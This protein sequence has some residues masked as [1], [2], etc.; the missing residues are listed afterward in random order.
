MRTVILFLL[1]INIC[2]P[3]Y[4]QVIKGTIFDQKTDSV[5]CFATVYFNGT[6]VGTTSDVNGNFKLNVSKNVSMPLTISAVGYYSLTLTDYSTS[7]PLIIYLKP[8]IYD[9]SEAVISS[10]S[11]ERKRRRNLILFKEEFLGTTDNAQECEILNEKD[12]TFNYDSDDD[13]VKAFALKPIL[14]ENKVLGYKITYYLD[15]FEYYKGKQATFFSGNIIFQEDVTTEETQ[16]Q[17]AVMRK[18]AYLG[19]RMHFFR[20]LWSNDLKSNG[21]TVNNSSYKSLQPKEIVIQPYNNKYLSY[22]ENL[23]VDY[24]KSVS[25]IHFLKK[26]V[27][28]DNTGYFDPSGINWKGRMA[29]QRIADW[30]PYEYSIE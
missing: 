13:T 21:F 23:Y 9:L 20:A 12:I 2:I 17:L 14:V 29:Q 25:Y 11:L 1:F 6:F 26:N 18:N 3:T 27:Y 16:K 28:F 19:S 24:G 22:I 10:K 5:I 15:K 7:G 30:L 8:K 4:S